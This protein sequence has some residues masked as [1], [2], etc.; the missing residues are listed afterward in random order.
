LVSSP[1]AAEYIIYSPTAAPWHL[2]ECADTAFAD[3]LVV[4]DEADGSS[5]YAPQNSR[6]KMMQMY[7]GKLSEGT[8]LW[9]YAF[10]KRSYVMRRNGKGARYPH[11]NKKH[12]FPLTYSIAE[13]YLPYKFNEK[14]NIRIMCTLRAS[15]HQPSRSRV[16][17]WVTKYAADFAV[18]QSQLVIGQV[19]KAA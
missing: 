1:A 8:V 13:S 9:Y 10:F 14:R 19:G 5:A 18:P 16:V 6:E 2:S 17:D 15:K 3:R 11:L 4:L 7:P 12:F